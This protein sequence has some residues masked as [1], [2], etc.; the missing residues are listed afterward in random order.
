M[1]RIKTEKLKD[2]DQQQ[3]L[4][5]MAGNIIQFFAV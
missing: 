5:E 2:N 4:R 3:R 1:S